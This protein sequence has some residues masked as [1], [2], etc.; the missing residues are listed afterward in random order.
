MPI[1]KAFSK[2][3]LPLA[4]ASSNGPTQQSKLS[5]PGPSGFSAGSAGFCSVAGFCSSAAQRRG[6]DVA[7]IASSK[8]KPVNV[9]F[10]S[11][12]S[13][14]TNAPSFSMHKLK[15]RKVKTC[16]STYV[17]LPLIEIHP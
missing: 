12:S 16:C 3:P 15:L 13:S 2:A 1:P 8:T 4:I 10:I 9:R 17:L 6:A 11:H 5:H 14:M 7:K